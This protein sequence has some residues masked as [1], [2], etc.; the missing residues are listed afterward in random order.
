MK[1]QHHHMA[2]KLVAYLLMVSL[3]GVFYNNLTFRHYHKLADGRVIFHAHPYNKESKGCHSHTSHQY[4]S[5]QSIFDLFSAAS[6]VPPINIVVFAESI[7][8]TDF[9]KPQDFKKVFQAFQNKA[10]PVCSFS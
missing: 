5:L 10:P 7:A 4:T 6:F 1:H 9:I 3:A 2:N 8:Y